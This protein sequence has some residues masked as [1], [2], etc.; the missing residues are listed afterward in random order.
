MN[1]PAPYDPARVQLFF[2]RY[3][4]D[5]GVVKWQGFYLSDHTAALKKQAAQEAKTYPAKPKQTMETISS[6]LADAFAN[7]NVVSIQLNNLDVNGEYHPDV[8]G[9]LAGYQDEM[10]YMNEKAPMMISEIRHVE[11]ERGGKR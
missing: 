1:K 4:K 8:V 3:Y 5:R 6:L 10:I 7:G 2:D 9:R 11:I